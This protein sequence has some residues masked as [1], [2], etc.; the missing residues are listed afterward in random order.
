MFPSSFILRTNCQLQ[1]KKWMTR[2]RMKKHWGLLTQQTICSKNVP[3]ACSQRPCVASAASSQEL[4]TCC[5]LSAS[6]LHNHQTGAQHP[7]GS[8]CITVRI[9]RIIHSLY[10]TTAEFLFPFLV[11]FSSIWLIVPVISVVFSHDKHTFWS[12]ETKNKP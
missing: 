9:Y 6:S 3:S 5:S 4:S 1:L 8:L 2:E 12:R 11:K 10:C 7:T